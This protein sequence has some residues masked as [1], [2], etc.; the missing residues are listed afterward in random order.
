MSADPKLFK[1]DRNDEK[2]TY[3]RPTSLEI[4]LAG[5]FVMNDLMLILK[6][7]LR[8]FIQILIVHLVELASGFSMT[9]RLAL[10]LLFGFFLFVILI[11]LYIDEP[12]LDEESL[13][14]ELGFVTFCVD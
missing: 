9:G 2:K 6:L 8:D 10:A 3:F 14:D 4:S 1:Y 12:S 11:E 13:S 5:L 7:S